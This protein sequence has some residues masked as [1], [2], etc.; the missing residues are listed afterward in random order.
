[1]KGTSKGWTWGRYG[2]GHR[3][4]ALVGNKDLADGVSNAALLK[5]CKL[6]TGKHAFSSHVAPLTITSDTLRACQLI[7]ASGQQLMGHSPPPQPHSILV[8]RGKYPGLELWY[9]WK[10]PEFIGGPIWNKNC[11]RNELLSIFAELWHCQWQSAIGAV[12]SGNVPVLLL[13]SCNI[14]NYQYLP[15]V[16]GTTHWVSIWRQVVCRLTELTNSVITK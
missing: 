10:L 9:H 5:R 2:Q 4:H 15:H 11:L 1:M 7:G 14:N 12:L 6:A 3:C 16:H 13:Y 8:T